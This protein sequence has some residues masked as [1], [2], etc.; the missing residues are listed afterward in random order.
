MDTEKAKKKLRG[1][2]IGLHQAKRLCQLPER[3]RL[4]F[5]AEGL[6]V[7]LDSAQSFWKAAQQLSNHHREAE[8]LRGFAEEEA[9][10]ILILMD[11]VRC[12]PKLI[13]SKLGKLV[14]W[15]Y[16][17]LAR[18]IYAQ[19]VTWKPMHLAQLREYVDRRRRG[20]ELE[21]YAGEYILP[22]WT[23][24]QRESR[25]YTD[26]E[27]YQ[28][29]SL[30]W[31]SPCATYRSSSAAGLT[32]MFDR[33]PHALRVA[34]AM[35]HLGLFTVQGLRAT[36]EIWGSL[37][38]REKENHLDGEKLAEQLLTRAKDEG[39][40]LDTAQQAHAATLYREWQ[41]PMYN[42]DLS[43]IPVPFEEL[44]AEQEREYWSVA[45]DPR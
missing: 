15:F 14:D 1:P 38:Y 7:I 21:G 35:Q 8:V 43:L 17:H 33:T 12:P 26:I 39:L 31:N 2:D 19:A 41:I 5:I 10:K 3:E 34:E 40:I 44:L 42:L 13:A 24:Y 16:D 6:P 25:L 29:G 45:G 20:H 30:G 18:L 22:N 11:V 32:S 28:D 27:A 4:L 23:V 36:S 9:A 37:E